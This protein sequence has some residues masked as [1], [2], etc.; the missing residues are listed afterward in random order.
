MSAS[1]DRA[2]AR[3]QRQP[4]HRTSSLDD[5]MHCDLA[6][7]RSRALRHAALSA[8]HSARGDRLLQRRCRATA[9]S[10]A[11][12]V[13]RH[14][15]GSRWHRVS[16]WRHSAG[17]ASALGRYETQSGQLESTAAC[18]PKATPVWLSVCSHRNPTLL[19]VA[20][21]SRPPPSLR[22]FVHCRTPPSTHCG[23]P[24][25]I[26]V[27]TLVSTRTFVVSHTHTSSALDL[28]IGAPL[29]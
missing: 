18:A 7:N 6:H 4:A 21:R 16:S 14:A 17:S 24:S 8:P 10:F 29:A 15:I 23:S 26:S 5:S 11:S 28:E 22:S 19:T 3:E 1:S 27:V 2:A 12:G 9:R 13:R 25:S 20:I